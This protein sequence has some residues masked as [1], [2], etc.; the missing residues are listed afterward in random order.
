MTMAKAPKPVIDEKRGQNWIRVFRTRTD[1]IVQVWSRGV[2]EGSPDGD[3]EMPKVLGVEASIAQAVLQT[4]NDHE[5]K[6]K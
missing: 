5:D 6:W 4:Q 2:P 1:I 3:W